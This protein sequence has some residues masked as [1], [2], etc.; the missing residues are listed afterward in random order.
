MKRMPAW[1]SEAEPRGPCLPRQKPGKQMASVR[2]MPMTP[3]V[4]I[5]GDG[6]GPEVMAATRE[7]VAAA[8]GRIQWIDAVAGMAAMERYGEPLPDVTLELI[9]KH[10]VAL[11][12]PC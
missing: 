11:K 6:I 8:G 5:P 4:M 10:R 1:F 2:R 3:V 12:G 7:I 9:R